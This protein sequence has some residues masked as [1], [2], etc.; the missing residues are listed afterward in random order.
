MKGSLLS[1]LALLVATRAWLP[2]RHPSLPSR[3]ALRRPLPSGQAMR[4]H[5]TLRMADSAPPTQLTQA[6]IVPSEPFRPDLGVGREAKLTKVL[7]LN[8]GAVN[9][10]RVRV[11]ELTLSA[12]KKMNEK[13]ADCCLIF[14]PDGSLAGIFTER[15]YIRKIV[16]AQRRTKET[17]IEEVMTSADLVVSA[18]PDMTVGEC[19]S[20]MVQ[21]KIRHI[22]VRAVPEGVVMGVISTTDLVNTMKLDDESLAGAFPIGALEPSLVQDILSRTRERANELAVKAGPRLGMQDLVRGGWVG[23][24]AGVLALLLQGN[25][26][27]DH[28]V[29]SMCAIFGLGYVSII[30]ENIFEFNKAAV[31]LLMAVALW[32]IYAGTAGAQGV[33]SAGAL[34]E[35]AEHVSEVSEI[36]FFLLGAMTIVEI[37]DS[38]QGFRVVTDLIKTKSKK[39][40]MWTVGLLAFFMSSVLDNLTTTIVLLSLLRKLIP[41]TEARKLFGALVVIA[42]N[43]GG[44][45]TPIGD[46]TTTML[47]INGQISALPTMRDLAVPSLVSLLISTYLLT[48]GIPDTD[49]EFEEEMARNQQNAVNTELAPRGKL[50]FAT[51]LTG[52]LSVPVFKALTGL[53]PYLG[54]LSA[55]GVMWVLTDTIHAGEEEEE[56]K[57]PAA[58]AKIDVSGILFFFGILL[59][60]GALDSAGILQSLASFLQSHIPSDKIIATLIGIFSA[61]IDNVP[62]VAATMSMYDLQTT[63]MDA[64]LWQLVAYCAGTGGSLLVIGSAAGVALMGLEK[65]DFL[66]YFK[67]I[68]FAAFIGYMGGVGTYLAVKY[69]LASAVSAAVLPIVSSVFDGKIP[70]ISGM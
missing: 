19:M 58:L 69:G 39:A 25:W 41:N 7:E 45:W 4:H 14:N 35:L 22:P 46:L 8:E 43:A 70:L 34:K 27:H 30:F 23:V 50:V 36:I 26:L 68:T 2:V 54:M 21:N 6:E 44:A 13:G 29:L 17:P 52:L 37:V 3:V 9:F 12:V 61:I 48:W 40:L 60:V 15:D 57:V 38:H 31:G 33:A 64:P 53:P 1:F 49:R 28:E 56:L 5:H 55:L 59:S 65:V 51:G 32:V 24:G 62:L 18:P 66:W 42:S 16:E 10:V 11:D 63:P 47:W 20:L 67:K